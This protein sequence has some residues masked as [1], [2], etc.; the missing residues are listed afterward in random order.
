MGLRVRDSGL[1]EQLEHRLSAHILNHK[2]DTERT[3]WKRSFDTHR[4][5]FSHGIPSPARL[6]LLMHAPTSSHQLGIKTH[7][8]HLI[9]TTTVRKQLSPQSLPGVTDCVRSLSAAE[10]GTP[11]GTAASTQRSEPSSTPGH[12]QTSTG[13]WKC[14]QAQLSEHLR[15][16]PSKASELSRARLHT[17]ISHLTSDPY[18]K[19]IRCMQTQKYLQLAS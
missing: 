14:G 5:P 7:R 16:S 6:C 10:S 15:H 18:C 17:S 11:P 2:Q 8:G 9:Q 12:L 13:K 1:R 3:N 4:L 19:Q